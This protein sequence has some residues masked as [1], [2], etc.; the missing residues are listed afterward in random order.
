MWRSSFT[1]CCTS[2]RATQKSKS[3][4]GP[5]LWVL[6]SFILNKNREK[7]NKFVPAGNL[8]K[9]LKYRICVCVFFFPFCWANRFFDRVL[10]MCPAKQLQ[11]HRIKKKSIECCCARLHAHKNCFNHWGINF[12]GDPSVDYSFG[13]R[14]QTLETPENDVGYNLSP[15]QHSC[16]RC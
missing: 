9:R 12:H 15:L 7:G 16:S 3:V 8:A 5:Q 6:A 13:H 4:E 1:I 11:L 14:S 10:L 2:M